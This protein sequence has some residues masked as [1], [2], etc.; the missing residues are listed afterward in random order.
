MCVLALVLALG[1][2]ASAGASFENSAQLAAKKGAKG[3]ACKGKAG[4]QKNAGKS[5]AATAQAKKKGKKQTCKGKSKATGRLSDGTYSDQSQSLQV[6]ISGGGT[7]ALLE[8]SPPGFCASIDY[9]SEPVK[10]TKSGNAWKASET[11]TLSIGGLPATAKWDL[12]VKAPALTYALNFT[13]ELESPIVGACKGEG[14]PTGT[15]TKGG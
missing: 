12:T 6:T 14:H 4:E 8:Y 11:R 1:M 7:T 10:F 13:L 5:A 3:K 15:L 9:S 2:G